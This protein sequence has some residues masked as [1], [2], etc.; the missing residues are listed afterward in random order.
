MIGGAAPTPVNRLRKQVYER[1]CE[2][3]Q[4]PAGRFSLTVPTGGGK[5]LASLGFA[6]N[7]AK[8]HGK[9]RVVYVIP[10]TSIIEQTADVFRKVFAALGRDVVIEH[11]SNAETAPESESQRTRLAC[12]NW[13]AP[14]IVTTSVQFFESLYAARTSRVRKLHN[15]VDSIVILD[16]ASARSASSCRP[17]RTWG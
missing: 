3:A 12:E 5:T 14:L 11:H 9:R 6:L 8:A 16:E 1:C 10:Y 2:R 13:D 15:L 7:H 4:E 17:E